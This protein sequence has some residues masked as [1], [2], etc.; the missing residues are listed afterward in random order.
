M[1]EW[2]HVWLTGLPRIQRENKDYNYGLLAYLGSR[3]RTRTTTTA[4]ALTK[5][6]YIKNYGLCSS[7][8]DMITSS[9]F[10]M[11]LEPSLDKAL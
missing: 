5:N 1:W 10:L 8:L 2:D 3:G 7:H 9:K 6:K 11:Q 4:Y